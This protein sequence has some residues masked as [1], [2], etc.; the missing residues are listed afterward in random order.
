MTVKNQR[1]LR[2]FFFDKVCDRSLILNEGIPAVL[3]AEVAEIRIAF[4]RFAVTY[5]VIDNNREALCAE[6]P[7]HI[8]ISLAVLRHTVGN[9]KNC[10]N[11]V[12]GIPAAHKHFRNARY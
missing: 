7:C 10:L 6:I 3:L 4:N 9:L 1:N 11:A 8:L 12:I 2:K 5:M